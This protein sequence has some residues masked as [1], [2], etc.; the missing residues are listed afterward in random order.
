MPVRCACAVWRL[1]AVGLAQMTPQRTNTPIGIQQIPC[2]TNTVLYYY[3]E[4][5]SEH[6][7]CGETLRVRHHTTAS[8]SLWCGFTTNSCTSVNMM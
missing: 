2:G 5:V 3:N 8:A 7:Q 6:E 1:W 4:T